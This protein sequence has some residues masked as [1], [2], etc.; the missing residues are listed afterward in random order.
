MTDEN[1][2]RK[3]TTFRGK[4]KGDRIDKS[5]RLLQ[6]SELLLTGGLSQTEIADALNIHKS[7]VSR[8][9]KELK[10]QWRAEYSLNTAALMFDEIADLQ[11]LERVLK[12]EFF[13]ERKRAKDGKR[14]P[15]LSTIGHI[16][17]I[18]E[19]TH[20]IMG[21]DDTRAAREAAVASAM[22]SKMMD[23]LDDRLKDMT[24]VEMEQHYKAI[25]GMAVE[26]TDTRD[27]SRVI[28]VSSEVVEPS[29]EHSDENSLQGSDAD[30][31]AKY[32]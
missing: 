4:G 2:P 19:R 1:S 21:L 27:T 11:A 15:D 17:R 16:L 32:R 14:H 22:A 26:S 25:I 23:G 9:V 24:P 28:D 10:D 13:A 30:V 5:V 7:Q 3:Q 6:V 18:K 31:L 8:Y 20:R 29:A 12:R